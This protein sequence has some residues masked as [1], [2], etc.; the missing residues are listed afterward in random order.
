M[1]RIFLA[2]AALLVALPAMADTVPAQQM[3]RCQAMKATLAPKQ[4]EIDAAA[5][6][7]DA[8][9]EAAEAE[10]EAYEDAQVLRL[11]SAANAQAADAAKARFDAARRAFAQAEF[12]L[13]ANVRQFNQDVADYNRSCTPAK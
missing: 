3:Q 1:I 9:A 13:H 7:R 2:S 11:A 10:G 6:Q 8:L 4:A 12:A 5:K